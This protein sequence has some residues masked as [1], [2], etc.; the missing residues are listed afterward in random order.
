MYLYTGEEF[1]FTILEYCSA[2]V[3]TN[4]NSLFYV[5][6]DTEFPAREKFFQLALVLIR[7]QKYLLDYVPPAIYDLLSNILLLLNIYHII[8]LNYLH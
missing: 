7:I 4:N 6:I 8:A 2:T 5:Y 3:V 1:F